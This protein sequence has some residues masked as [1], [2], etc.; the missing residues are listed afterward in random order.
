MGGGLLVL[1]LETNGPPPRLRPRFRFTPGLSRKG[2]PPLRAGPPFLD[3]PN[4]HRAGQ[5]RREGGRPEAGRRQAG[6]DGREHEDHEEGTREAIRSA[7][8]EGG[9][10]RRRRGSWGGADREERIGRRAM[11]VSSASGSACVGSWCA[12]SDAS[13]RVSLDSRRTGVVRPA[14][15]CRGARPLP[16]GVRAARAGP[17]RADRGGGRRRGVRR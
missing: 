14:R 11:W 6:R 1:V 3:L 10:G 15:A 12:T 8:V 4:K 5:P 17:A 2:G 7:E 16:R 13:T 9:E